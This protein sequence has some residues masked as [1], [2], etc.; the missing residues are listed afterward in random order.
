MVETGEQIKIKPSLK[1][2]HIEC[3]RQS[4]PARQM[5]NTGVGAKMEVHAECQEKTHRGPYH[6]VRVKGS[7]PNSGT[8]EVTNQW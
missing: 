2:F 8:D 1:E 7:F 3:G 6:G 5:C 4:Y